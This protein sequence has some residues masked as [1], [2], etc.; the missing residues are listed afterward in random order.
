MSGVQALATN[1]IPRF[2]APP[3]RI[4]PFSD[5]VAP[6]DRA[7][8]NDAADP[9]RP[10]IAKGGLTPVQLKRVERFVEENYVRP[11]QVR[12]LATVSNLS[13]SYFS[14]AFTR[15][16]GFSPHLMLNRYRI[17]Q[18]ARLMLASDEPLVD[19]ALACGLCDQAHLSRL[20]RKFVGASPAHWRQAN[21]ACLRDQSREI[22]WAAANERSVWQAASQ[23]RQG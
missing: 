13:L 8:E 20:F 9:A 12:D 4:H 5:V 14:R 11:I 18:A 15:S 6:A 17:M 16:V 3:P 1:L 23:G 10:L 21:A 19:I 2:Q 7:H 22:P